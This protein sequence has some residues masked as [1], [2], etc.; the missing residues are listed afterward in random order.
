MWLPKKNPILT[1]RISIRA[2][3][4]T[5]TPSLLCLCLCTGT[6]G[7]PLDRNLIQ[8]ADSIKH[9]SY[10]RK[11]KTTPKIPRCFLVAQPAAWA[12]GRI[13]WIPEKG[14]EHTARGGRL[15]VVVNP[16]RRQPQKARLPASH[17]RAGQG[18]HA[19]GVN[20]IVNTTH[21]G[22]SGPRITILCALPSLTDMQPSVP[23]WSTSNS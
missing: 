12:P 16:R 22:L 6:G 13:R 19:E 23:M 1:K 7:P 15:S 9:R 3:L 17:T 4:V 10:L 21:S 14:Q 8:R 2:A 18:S 11:K 5:P 20:W